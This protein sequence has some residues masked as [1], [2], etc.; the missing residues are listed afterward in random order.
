MENQAHLFRSIK[1]NELS[2]SFKFSSSFETI[3]LNQLL[4]NV[5]P[6]ILGS[7]RLDMR[8]REVELVSED[9]NVIENVSRKFNMDIC[10]V[11]RLNAG[12]ISCFNEVHLA[13]MYPL[14]P[15]GDIPIETDVWY[16]LK[17]AEIKENVEISEYLDKDSD[18]RNFQY[19]GQNC[20]VFLYFKLAAGSHFPEGFEFIIDNDVEG[21]CII[22]RTDFEIFDAKYCQIGGGF[23][24]AII[25]P[26]IDIGWT[27]DGVKLHTAAEPTEYKSFYDKDIWSLAVII[28][29][30]FSCLSTEQLVNDAIIILTELSTYNY[31]LYSNTT[32]ISCTSSSTITKMLTRVL[33]DLTIYCDEQELNTIS[34]FKQLV[35]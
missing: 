9:G 7:F 23:N 21:H 15:V 31:D 14:P 22:R 4:S 27:F 35:E 30:Y 12:G 24:Y 13:N 16:Y 17:S 18:S 11:R 20:V 6:K 10:R 8:C 34:R 3:T 1:P 26:L 25:A 32:D 5:P 33:N 2:T 28:H 19:N 29:E